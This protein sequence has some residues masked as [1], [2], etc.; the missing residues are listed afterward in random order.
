MFKC[1]A[2]DTLASLKEATTILRQ[3]QEEEPKHW[4]Y[5]LNAQ[6]FDGGLYLI[7]EKSSNAP[8]GFTGFQVRHE[9][10]KEAGDLKRIG[11]YS[12]GILPE[13]RNNG[14]AKQAVARLI[15][16]KKASVDEVR[17]MIVAG[18]EPSMALA[19]S[20]NVPVLVKRA[21]MIVRG[22]GSFEDA[23]RRIAVA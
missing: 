18:N 12:I 14:Y 10:S 16:F 5:G 23:L 7:R 13:Y 3:I 22:A 6:H 15:N 4:P 21:S 1:A 8:V 19:R 20:L 11:F 9:F 17:A 2:V